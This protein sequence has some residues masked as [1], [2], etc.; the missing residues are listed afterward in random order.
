MLVLCC[1]AVSRGFQCAGGVTTD[2][3]PL[4]NAAPGPLA[5]V[6]DL[7]ELSERHGA[8]CEELQVP[9][10]GPAAGNEGG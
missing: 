3:V 9:L 10:A 5:S 1:R 7:L 4:I 2:L 6:L 8:E